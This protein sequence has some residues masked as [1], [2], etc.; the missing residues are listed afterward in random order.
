MIP[1]IKSITIPSFFGQSFIEMP[2]LNAYTRLSVELEFLTF[3]EN[4]LLVYNGQTANGEGDFISI[5]I[6]GGKLIGNHNKP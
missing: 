1:P 3:S 5:S 4:G 6:K 2:R